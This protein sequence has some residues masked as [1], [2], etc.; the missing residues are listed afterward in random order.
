[1]LCLL[2]DILDFDVFFTENKQQKS[3]KRVTDYQTWRV[4]ALVYL[5]TK[6]LD[7]LAE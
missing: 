5:V 3:S 6:K 7:K 1:M 2:S 4:R